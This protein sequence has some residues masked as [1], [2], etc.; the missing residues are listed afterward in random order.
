MHISSFIAFALSINAV[1]AVALQNNAAA[2]A[3][4]TSC[5][6]CYQ[7]PSMINCPVNGGIN[8]TQEALKQAAHDADRSGQ[9]E[10]WSAADASS[11][12]CA[13]PRFHNI[14]YWATKLP[15]SAGTL[16]YALAPN[17]TFYFCS[18][19]SGYRNGW[20]GSCTEYK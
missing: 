6:T 8:I 1:S 16:F 2:P 20:P 10:D 18:T 17:G 19:M 13:T 14:P 12:H 11:G 4:P 3:S 15:N 7:F 5:D 9:P